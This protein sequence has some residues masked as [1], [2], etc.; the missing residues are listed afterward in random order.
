MTIPTEVWILPRPRKPYYPGSF[1]LHFEIK[2]C[3]LLNVTNRILHTFG[4]YAEYGL[5]MDIDI[6]TL[7]NVIGDAHKVPFR[8]NYFNLVICDPPYNDKLS[9]TMYDAPPVRYGKYMSEAVRVC[10]KNKY[11]ASYHWYWTIKP[12][13]TEYEKIIIVLPGQRHRPRI[14]CIYKKVGN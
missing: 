9:M 14:C 13:G 1:P 3:R 7:P 2:L 11:I 6:N 8:S 10:K 5:C 12:K 4:G